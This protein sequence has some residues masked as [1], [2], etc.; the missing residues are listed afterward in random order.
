MKR[1]IAAALIALTASESV[2]ASC[3]FWTHRE[4]SGTSCPGGIVS[5]Q[6]TYKSSWASPT[7]NT[8]ISQCT[9][10]EAQ[11]FY[12]FLEWEDCEGETRHTSYYSCCNIF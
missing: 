10:S 1:L 9:S 12:N 11:I 3:G 7:L 4:C 5:F 6:G 2:S 8:C